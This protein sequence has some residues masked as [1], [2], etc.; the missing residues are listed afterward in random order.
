MNQN[1]LDELHSFDFFVFE[2]TL[3][4]KKAVEIVCVYVNKS[5]GLFVHCVVVVCLFSHRFSRWYFRAYV[6]H[7]FVLI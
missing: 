4:G 6:A 1:S 7:V 5:V 2:F 3:S